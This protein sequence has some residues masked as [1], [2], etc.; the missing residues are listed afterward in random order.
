MPWVS[1]VRAE[2]G[3]HWAALHSPAPRLDLGC[4]ALLATLVL[5]AVAAGTLGPGPY[6]AVGGM[7]AAGVAVALIAGARSFRTTFDGDI[8]QA[9]VETHS[10]FGHSVHRYPFVAI[11][12]L[13]VTEGLRG[14]VAAARRHQ[15]A[16]ELRAR[17]LPASSTRWCPPFA[18]RPA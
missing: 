3:P 16:A 11:D 10:V 1:D 14:G 7:L 6:L 2:I 13:N 5:G 4:F 8:G 18:P 12:A 17:D 9:T 15:R